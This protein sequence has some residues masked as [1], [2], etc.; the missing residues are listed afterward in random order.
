MTYFLLWHIKE[1]I[2][3]NVL[4]CFVRRVEVSGNQ[5]CLLTKI[6]QNIFILFH[7]KNEWLKDDIFLIWVN[8]RFKFPVIL[9]RDRPIYR[10]TDIFPDI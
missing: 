9:F 1:G 4:V 2:L 5:N 10:F 8:Y 3:N 6:P 7:R